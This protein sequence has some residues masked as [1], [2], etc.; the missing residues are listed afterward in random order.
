VIRNDDHFLVDILAEIDP[1]PVAPRDGWR[2]IEIRFLNGSASGS[3][4]TCL[5]RASFPPGATHER[6]MHPNADEFFYLISGRA[7]VGAGD[8]E[9]VASGG[10]VQFIPAGRVH[11]LRNLDETEP[12]EVVGVYVGGASLEDAGYVYAGEIS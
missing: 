11:W 7:A 9:Q 1:E 4:N 3:S 8:Q 2:G 10:T 12:V 5:F 6:H